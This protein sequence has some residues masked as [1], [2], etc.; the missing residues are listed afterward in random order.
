MQSFYSSIARSGIG[1]TGAEAPGIKMRGAALEGPLFRGVVASIEI[2]L[3][4]SHGS[5]NLQPPRSRSCRKEL[6]QQ[7]I[8]GPRKVAFVDL[9]RGLSC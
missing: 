7:D 9:N 3:S 6:F 1:L 2:H 5:E 8:P 4:R